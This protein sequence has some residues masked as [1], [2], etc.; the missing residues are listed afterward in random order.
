MHVIDR[1]VGMDDIDRHGASLWNSTRTHRLGSRTR[2]GQTIGEKH[3][4]YRAM[5]VLKSLKPA[6]TTTTKKLAQFFTKKSIQTERPDVF[7]SDG[8]PLLFQS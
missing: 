2:F 5:E 6:T 1:L 3:Q 4:Q 8:A 7:F